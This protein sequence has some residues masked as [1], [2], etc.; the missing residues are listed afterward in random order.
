VKRPGEAL[1]DNEAEAVLRDAWESHQHT[2]GDGWHD[3]LVA[4][5]AQDVVL[6]WDGKPDPDAPPI[7]CVRVDDT[8]GRPTWRAMGE[9][10]PELGDGWEVRLGHYSWRPVP[11]AP[12]HAYVYRVRRALPAAPRTERVP[13]WKALGRTAA[14]GKVIT[15]A[16]ADEPGV[17]LRCGSG[18]AWYPDEDGTVEVLVDGAR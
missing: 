8:D 15:S 6:V 17:V 3:F 11:A 9:D 2:L 7:P 18:P 10:V 13:W 1:D 4:L 14:G 5:N 16:E 12:W